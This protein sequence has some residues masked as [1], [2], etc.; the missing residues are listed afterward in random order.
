M[1]W[2]TFATN[3]VLTAAD[4]NA[5]TADAS[6]ADVVTLQTTATTSYTD[7]ATTGP[8]VTLTLGSGQGCLVFIAA[9]GSNSLGGTSGQACFSFAVSGATTLAANDSNGV[10]SHAITTPGSQQQMSLRAT[11]FA[12][13]ATGSHTFTMKYKAQTGGTAGFTER[14]IIV[15]K[16]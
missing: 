2:K 7:L 5:I 6:T 13:T 1:P 3:D 10:E 9:R 11:W 8:A 14:R 4:M 12:A 16:F 15:K